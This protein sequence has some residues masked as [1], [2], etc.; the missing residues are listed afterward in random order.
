M[1]FD[2]NI[3]RICHQ[4]VGDHILA[5]EIKDSDAAKC[6]YCGTM[7]PGWPLQALAERI[8]IAFQEHYIRTS[9]EPSEWQ[10]ALLRDG[11]SR[12]D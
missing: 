4:C 8:E 2:S 11:E 12:Y 5:N 6:S 3:L 10:Y 1:E 7:L 9:P